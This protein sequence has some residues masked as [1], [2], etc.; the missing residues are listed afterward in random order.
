[1]KR[2]TFL[3]ASALGFG[4]ALMPGLVACRMEASENKS[5]PELTQDPIHTEIPSKIVLD[6]QGTN[7]N[8]IGDNQ[9]LKLSGKDTDGLFTLIEQN[10]N[11]GM[12]IPLHLHENEDE[13]FHVIE[14]QLEVIVGD[15]T[16]ILKPGDLGFLPRKIP[17]S[18]RVTGDAP[19]KVLLSIFPAGLEVMF[20]EL[21]KLE[22]GP[23]DLKL[24]A[25]IASKYDIR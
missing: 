10:N 13:I 22:P 14:G 4:A 12:G 3:K 11:P 24:V 7:M 18:W 17:H 16:T 2:K 1:M 23:P 25:G 21:S 6:S 5:V 15:T 8:V 9:T 20:A 19:A